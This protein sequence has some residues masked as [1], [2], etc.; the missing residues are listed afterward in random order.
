[1]LNA[2]WQ[3]TLSKYGVN[4]LNIWFLQLEA[5]LR[6]GISGHKQLNYVRVVGALPAEIATEFGDITY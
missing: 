1:M 4:N 6:H 5:L 3:F 2:I